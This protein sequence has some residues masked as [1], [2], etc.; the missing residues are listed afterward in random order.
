MLSNNQEILLRASIK[1]WKNKLSDDPNAPL[2]SPKYDCPLCNEFFNELQLNMC[3][4]C[5]V[6]LFT[7]KNN[8]ASVPGIDTRTFW[9]IPSRNEQINLVVSFGNKILESHN[10]KKE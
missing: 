6:A 3:P 4:D 5:P 7:G 8:C 1:N 2:I 9:R 10:L